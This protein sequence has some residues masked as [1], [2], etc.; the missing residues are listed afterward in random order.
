MSPKNTPGP[1]PAVAVAGVLVAGMSA[2]GEPTS[3]LAGR[4][5]E[6]AEVACPLEPP[7]PTDNPERELQS[8]VPKTSPAAQAPGGGRLI[9]PQV[10]GLRLTGFAPSVR[11]GPASLGGLPI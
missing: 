2:L 1:P 7:K 10:G 11:V 5:D 3:V 4:C 8:G 9:E 6:P